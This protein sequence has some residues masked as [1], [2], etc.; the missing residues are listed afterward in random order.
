VTYYLPKD[1]FYNYWTGAVVEGQGANVTESGLS[2]SDIPIHVRAGSI[3]SE[4]L[5]SANTTKA[6]RREPYKITAY[7]AADGTAKGKLYQDDGESIE[8]PGASFIEY[9]YANGQFSTT[10]SFGYAAASGESIT[11]EQIVI[12]GQDNAGSMGS[13]DSASNKVTVNGPWKLNGA[14]SI[15]I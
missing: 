11:V 4:R 7:L 6:L 1:R 10:G 2:S 14:W 13:F 12:M 3:I 9:T 8:Q 5:N 15:N